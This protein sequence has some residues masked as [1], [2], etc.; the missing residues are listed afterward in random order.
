M[1]EGSAG[2]VT[3]VVRD[4][5]SVRVDIMRQKSSPCIMRVIS[6]VSRS[7]F[8][9]SSLVDWADVMRLSIVIPTQDLVNI[10]LWK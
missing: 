8:R 7:P 10:S 3:V 1:M 5:P 9:H 2:W 4:V 6:D